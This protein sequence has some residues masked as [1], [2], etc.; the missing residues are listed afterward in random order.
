MKQWIGE[1]SSSLDTSQI[2][3]ELTFRSLGDVLKLADFAP[4]VS[5]G[6]SSSD[7]SKALVLI[8]SKQ[9]N[10]ATTLNSGLQKF[11]DAFV[12]LEDMMYGNS[13]VL[14]FESSLCLSCESF[15]ALETT[16][17]VT[18]LPNS[19]TVGS[20]HVPCVRFRQFINFEHFWDPKC[21]IRTQDLNQGC[22]YD[23]ASK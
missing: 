13:S 7:V 20:G 8:K 1:S 11:R 17:R 10:G 23:K 19:K 4:L 18:Y 12:K 14:S 2:F 3:A 6:Q 21:M 15:P 16:I 5:L 22:R 9:A